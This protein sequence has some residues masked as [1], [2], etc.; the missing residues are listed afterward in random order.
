MKPI[1]LIMSAVGPYADL[2]P[3]INFEEFEE[4]GLFLISGNT[5][6]GKTT[7]FDAICFALFGVAS[8]SY[9]DTKNLRSD[10]A[11]PETKSY[12]DFYFSHQGTDYRIYRQPHMRDHDLEEEGM[13]T[14]GEKAIF[15]IGNEVPIEGKE[16]VNNAIKELL[17]INVKQFKQIAMIAQGEFW[18][19]LNVSTK[20]RTSILRNIFM[21][22]GYKNI[23][24]N[25]LERK[26][27]SG[28]QRKEIERSII[29][30]FN[31]TITG[32]ESLYKEELEQL[33]KNVTESKNVWNFD[34]LLEILVKIQDEEKNSFTRKSKELKIQEK[35]LEEK[36]AKLAQAELNNNAVKR[37]R[38]VQNK[39]NE[40]EQRKK[41][42]ENKESVLEC[43]KVAVRE[44]KPYYDP[45]VSKQKDIE[46][47]VEKINEK[48]VEKTTAMEELQRKNQFLEEVLTQ[49][50]EAEELKKRVEKIAEEEAKYEERDALVLE[51]KWL[52]KEWNELS[53]EKQEL[54]RK[55]DE[56]KKKISELEE[57]NYKLKDSPT[58]YIRFQE[59]ER[60]QQKLKNNLKKLQDEKIPKVKLKKNSLIEEQKIFSDKQ[61]V[62]EQKRSAY[63]VAEKFI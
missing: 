33:K 48:N 18:N 16:K 49:K 56:L 43:Q 15:Y 14:E 55:E 47:T 23:E 1:K 10:Y 46:K 61:K 2:T 42:M 5:G 32:E 28:N 54:D 40:L 13:T 3:E 59:I 58:E 25:L 39:K 17:N 50:T 36:Q 35:I 45:W 8:G 26:R 51:V 29:Q 6:A 24:F 52:E 20:E 62:Y 38:D 7:I 12:V 53:R 60:N 19:L 63:E 37:F 31:R 41:E 11:K 9:R 30:D 22:A 21:T 27:E 34:E 4:N 57:I 44:I